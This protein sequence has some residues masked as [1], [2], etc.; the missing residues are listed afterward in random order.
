MG[1]R[2]ILVGFFLLISGTELS[3]GRS[4]TRLTSDTINKQPFAFSIEVPAQ[5]HEG[6]ELSFRV[7]VRL[8]GE[9]LSPKSRFKGVLE[10]RD[11]KSLIASCSVSSTEE[12]GR[13]VYTFLVSERFLKDSSF[14]FGETVDTEDRVG[15]RY[16]WFYLG[17]FAKQRGGT[18]K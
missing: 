1:Q 17:D 2:I 3:A 10:M 4:S 13:M 16:Y 18:G 12:D 14:L 15:G 6:R 8:K 7:A 9:R 11:G 5:F